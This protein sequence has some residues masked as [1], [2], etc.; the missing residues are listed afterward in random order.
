[1]K[2]SRREF[3][4]GENSVIS[5]LAMV[6]LGLLIGLAFLP[7]ILSICGP[8]VCVSVQDVRKSQG[9]DNQNKTKESLSNSFSSKNEIDAATNIGPEP[10]GPES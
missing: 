5:F 10:N 6:S 8:V 7:A 3:L 1:M 9:N 2:I 4:V